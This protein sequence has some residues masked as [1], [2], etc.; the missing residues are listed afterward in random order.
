VDPTTLVDKVYHDMNSPQYNE[1]FTESYSAFEKYARA[2]K[3]QGR[4]PMTADTRNELF[5]VLPN[6]LNGDEEKNVS[7]GQLNP[8]YRKKDVS[9]EL[10]M[11][12]LPTR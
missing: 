5:K 12:A 4:Q 7:Q 1:V 9:R 3:G 10:C 11:R 8:L 2:R 6:T